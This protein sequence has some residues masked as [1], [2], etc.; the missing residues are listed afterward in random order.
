[1]AGC[2]VFDPSAPYVGQVLALVDCRVQAV[3][4]GGWHVLA[5]PGG[6]GPAL[7]ALMILAVALFGYRLMLGEVPGAGTVLGLAARM[8]LAMAL[9]TQWPAWDSL[10]YKVGTDAPDWLVSRLL[11]HDL[12]GAADRTGLAARIDALN[13]GIAQVTVVDAA[14]QVAQAGNPP[15]PATTALDEAQRKDLAGARAI[16]KLSALGGLLGIRLVIALLLASGPLFVLGILF[17]ATSTLFVGWARVMAG[18]I[19]ASLAVPLALMLQLAVMEPQVARLAG[20]AAANQPLG[21]LCAE[22]WTSAV[23]FALIMAIAAIALARAGSGLRLPAGVMHLARSWR[24]QAVPWGH[25]DP[26]PAP[27]GRPVAYARREERTR[28]QQLAD[29]AHALQRRDDSAAIAGVRLARTTIMTQSATARRDGIA[30]P[31]PWL[32]QSGPRRARRSSRGAM[33]RDGL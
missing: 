7:T 17:D 15:A 22:I 11:D 31:S 13:A 23:L 3:S 5:A 27:G 21:D 6:I 20:L 14:A 4:T 2:P 28:A 26:A 9:V 29:V 1:M 18:V 33:R 19:V 32:G 10:V 16:I 25:R 8:G 12:P 24:F 30:T